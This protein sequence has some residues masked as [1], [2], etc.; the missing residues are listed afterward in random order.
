MVWPPETTHVGTS[1]VR[2]MLGSVGERTAGLAAAW[3][4]TRA[5]MMKKER[6]VLEVAGGGERWGSAGGGAKARAGGAPRADRTTN[7]AY[8]K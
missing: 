8:N 4:P 2:T 5:A 7:L 6:I 3:V 1:P